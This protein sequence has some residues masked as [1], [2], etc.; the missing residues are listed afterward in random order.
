M[1]LSSYGL[2]IGHPIASRSHGGGHPHWLLMVA[3]AMA[4]HPPY[5][6]AVNLSGSDP[7][8][9]EIEFQMIDVESEGTAALKALVDKLR[10]HGASQSFETDGVPRLD[11]VRGG[12]LDPAKFQ[13]ADGNPLRSAFEKALSGAI[14][15]AQVPGALVAI[16]GTGT[17][18]DPHTGLAPGTGYTGVENVHMNQGSVNRTGIGH[19][20]GENGPNQD[21]GLIFLLPDGAKALFLKFRSQML[22]TDSNGNPLRTGVDAIDRRIPAVQTLLQQSFQQDAAAHAAAAAAAAPAQAPAPASPAPAAPPAPSASDFVFADD[23]PSD[24]GGTFVPDSDKGHYNTPFVMNYA[25]GKT[26]GPVPTPRNVDPL[27][28]ADIV[29]GAIPGYS[30]GADGSETIRFDMIGDSGAV[31]ESKLTGE[32]AVGNMMAELAGQE[33]N[34]PAFCFHVGDVVYFYG[35]KQFYYGQFADV[36]RRYPAPIFAIPGNHDAIIYDPSMVS[37]DAFQKA[38]CAEQPGRWDGFGGLTRSTMTQP[39]VYFALDA[40][41]VS[42]VGLYSNCGESLGWLDDPQYAFLQAQL[43][44][45]K[46]LR[47]QEK[48]AVILAIHHFPRWF[49]TGSDPMSRRID[50]ICQSV[51]LYPDAVVAG[52]AHLYQRIVRQD[53]A[54]AGGRAIPYFVNGAGG[55][56]I[57]ALEAVGR[58]FVKDKPVTEAIQ[59]NQEGFLRVT[60]TRK[61]GDATVAFQYYSTKGNGQPSDSYK[62]DLA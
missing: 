24:G 31:T 40:P 39:G 37:L 58:N 46:Q 3:P 38:F 55:Y 20:H 43:E 57:M 18:V 48:R 9:P 42:I 44:R 41:L 12:L 54:V 6:V 8:A 4:G 23:D 10:A 1:A 51:G 14:K 16:F 7:T 33:G 19:H 60:V 11:Y 29:G 26:R 15:T 49:P 47:A 35:E 45:L 56:G 34:A 27:N 62:L 28:L 2:L 13:T 22:D 25:K 59:I 32:Q 52:H 17:P 30:R 61:N 36:F 5:R 21:G 50:Q 53:P